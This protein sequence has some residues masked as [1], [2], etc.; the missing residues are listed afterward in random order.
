[1]RHGANVTCDVVQ[2]PHSTRHQRHARTGIGQ[3]QCNRTA[4]AARCTSDDR[5]TPVERDQNASDRL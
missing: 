1:M 5:V 4:D 3:G 2:I